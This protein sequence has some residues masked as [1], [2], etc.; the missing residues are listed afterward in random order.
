M[1]LFSFF[2]GACLPLLVVS[3]H[4]KSSKPAPPPHDEAAVVTPP[5]K[6]PVEFKVPVELIKGVDQAQGEPRPSVELKWDTVLPLAGRNVHWPLERSDATFLE[7]QSLT[8]AEPKADAV[9]AESCFIMSKRLMLPAQPGI[10]GFTAEFSP[11]VTLPKRPIKKAHTILFA[12]KFRYQFVDSEAIQTATMPYYEY[13]LDRAPGEDV[14]SASTPDVALTWPLVY[15]P[16]PLRWVEMDVCHP[17]TEQ[18]NVQWSEIG[19]R[20]MLDKVSDLNR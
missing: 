12:V 11:A 6:E 9:G 3:C 8:G 20:L 17:F 18:L 7:S 16:R 2:Y 1:R 19:L 4:K 5:D 13:M 10:L 15:I 14:R